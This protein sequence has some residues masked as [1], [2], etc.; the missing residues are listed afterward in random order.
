MDKQDPVSLMDLPTEILEKIFT[1]LSYDLESI[2][3]ISRVNSCFQQIG[4][5]VQFYLISTHYTKNTQGAI[6]FQQIKLF[7]TLI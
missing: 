5:K 3:S 4:T 2:K 6:F 7:S 1:C